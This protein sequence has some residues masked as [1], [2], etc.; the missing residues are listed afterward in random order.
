MSKTHIH[1]KKKASFYVQVNTESVHYS[2]NAIGQSSIFSVLHQSFSSRVY[3]ISTDVTNS[4]IDDTVTV[5]VIILLWRK[6]ALRCHRTLCIS[7]Q[8]WNKRPMF[9]VSGSADPRGS[10]WQ[11]KINGM[12]RRVHYLDV[13]GD[14]FGLGPWCCAF[15]WALI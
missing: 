15:K 6:S 12:L 4:S 9:S 5:N 2:V 13:F 11:S 7:V 10:H 14:I 8:S 3:I 1:L